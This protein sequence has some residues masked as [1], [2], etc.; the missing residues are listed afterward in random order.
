MKAIFSA[1]TS[2]L[3]ALL[4][5]LLT[6]LQGEHTGFETITDGQWVT[7]ALAFIVAVAGTG[8]VTYQVKNRVSEGQA[9]P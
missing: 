7:A 2:G 4:S 9:V 8:T 1:V 3:I 5:S 6:A